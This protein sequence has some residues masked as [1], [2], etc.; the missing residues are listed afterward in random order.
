MCSLLL[1]HISIPIPPSHNK[2]TGQHKMAT[3]RQHLEEELDLRY[4]FPSCHH[5][6]GETEAQPEQSVRVLVSCTSSKSS[7]YIYMPC[8]RVHPSPSNMM[9][10]HISGAGTLE[11]VY[12]I[13]ISAISRHII[14]I[15]S[16][17]PSAAARWT[18][19]VQGSGG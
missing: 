7:C 3:I 11:F 1:P 5:A 13:S 6:G 4:V 18:R 16:N 2:R 9:L 19:S 8:P 15:F 12:R 14:I 10:H 17:K